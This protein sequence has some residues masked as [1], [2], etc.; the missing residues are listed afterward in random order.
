MKTLKCTAILLAFVALLLSGC[1][2]KAQSPVGLPE[3]STQ[4]PTSLEKPIA[5]IKFTCTH[6]PTGVIIDPGKRWQTPGGIWQI[7]KVGVEENVLS[8]DPLVAG[9]MVHYLSA[10][11]DAAGEGPVH[12]SF[13]ITLADGGGMYWEG[14]YEGYRSKSSS[15]PGWEFTLPLKAVGHGRGGTIDGMKMSFDDLI[16][17]NGTPP[18]EW[19]GISNGFYR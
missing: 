6:I 19:Y 11:M 9:I 17:A 4:A 14:T 15:T 5:P 18:T 8:S 1:S 12:G 2:D 10:T 7:K 3:Q 16:R 13:K